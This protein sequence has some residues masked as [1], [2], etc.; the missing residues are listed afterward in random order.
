M[1]VKKNLILASASPRRQALLRQMGLIFDV[2]AS[3]VDEN[4]IGIQNPKEHVL[5]LS[6]RKAQDIAKCVEEGIVIGADTIV[7]L[8]GKILGKPSDHNDAYGML[9]ALSGR[10]HEVYT[11]LTLIDRP[12]NQII[13]ATERTRV[14]FRTLEEG[15][16]VE[17]IQSGAPL[18]KAGAYG[19]QD[20]Y[21][22]VFVEKI[23]GCFYNV[24]GFP[25][26]KFYL[27]FLEFQKQL[28]LL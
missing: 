22:A 3:N 5:A 6:E 25:L 13:S 27:I 8:E 26:T 24:V 4:N 28:G 21:G 12:S 17:Y 1:I 14:K 10:W 16:I 9:M 15:E 23:D 7:V 11:G 19:I 18:D 20:D 2:R